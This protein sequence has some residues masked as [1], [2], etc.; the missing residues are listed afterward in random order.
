M[1]A[2]TAPSIEADTEDRFGPGSEEVSQTTAVFDEM[3]EVQRQIVMDLGLHAQLLE[4]P[5]T[6]LGAAASRKVDIEAFFPSRTSVNSGYG[7][8]TSASICTDYQS[9]RLATRLKYP[10]GGK[11]SFPHT[12]NGTAIAIPRMLACVLE[13]GWNETSRT[14][15]IPECLRKWMPGQPATIGRTATSG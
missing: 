10:G 1:F 11:L 2:W 3:L 12:L 9:R 15:N 14:V 8:V 5:S 7:E 4:M 6:D 13:N